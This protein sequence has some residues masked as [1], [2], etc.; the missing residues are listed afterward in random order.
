MEDF[1]KF[2]NNIVTF[3]VIFFK[4]NPKIDKN[5]LA[6]LFIFWIL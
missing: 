2:Q 1:I 4:L 3:S 6:S 5:D